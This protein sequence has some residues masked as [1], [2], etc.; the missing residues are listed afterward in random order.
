MSA[1][2]R[3]VLPFARIG[4][5]DLP[6]VGGKT[7][8]LG[9]L[10]RALGPQG[11]AVPDGFAVTAAAY[12]DFLDHNGL[13]PVLHDLLDGLDVDDV[14]RLQE[15][16]AAAREALRG[17]S[18][19]PALA[20]EIRA[21]YARLDPGGRLSVAVRSSATAED[22][23]TASFAGQQETFLH[24]RG[25]DDVLRRVQDCFASLFLARA[26]AYR[27]HRGF[28]QLD[29]ALSVAVQ[30]MVRTDTGAAGV[31]FTLDPDTGHRGFVYLSGAWGLGENVV[32]GRVVPDAWYVH[33]STL[34]AGHDGVV[35][36]VLGTKATALRWDP[37]GG[38]L[39]DTPVP[40]A[41]R[42]RFCLDD[43]E[44]RQLARWALAV[45]AQFTQ[46]R[47]EPTPMDLEW[48]RDGETGELF[49]LQ[50]RPETVH[51]QRRTGLLRTWRLDATGH[52][53]LVEGLAVGGAVG[54]GT[55]RVC[56]SAEDLAAVQPGDVLV[57]RTTDPDWEPVM[58]VA[59]AIVTEEGGRTSHAAI[60]SR[61][62]GIPAVVAATGARSLLH[63]GQQITVSCAEGSIG[64]VYAGALAAEVE[65]VDLTTLPAPRT[66]ILVNVGDPERALQ[67]SLLPVDGVGLA[68]MEFVFAGWVGVHPL[69]LL[70]PERTSPEVQA[71]LARRCAGHATPQAWFVDRL[72][73]GIGMLAAAFH[74]RPV[75][76]RFSDFKSNEYAHLLG[77]EA[78]EPQEENPMIGW[79]GASRYHHPAFREAFAL[80]V[81]AVR[82]VREALGLTNLHLMIPFCRT[83]EEGRQ[84]IAELARGG[85]RR[86]DG[87]LELYV[88][89]EIPS[90]VLLAEEFAKDFDG[91]SI[92]SNDLTQ[93]VYGVDRDSA[94]V[95]DLF[96]DD[97]PALQRACAMLLEAAHGAGRKVG[98]CGQAPSDH[99]AFAAFLVEH[100]ID[101]ISLATDAVLATRQ[102][103][104]EAEQR[105]ERAR[106]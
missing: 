12:R 77:G 32:Q 81:A 104:V 43:E 2:S 90:N 87:G 28:G 70:H 82:Q 19:P 3:W 86:G 14:A 9:E 52:A 53:P 106:T 41:D 66:H 100:G 75:I 99:P 23:P 22:L 63:A 59:A 93:L 64:R 73:Q 69:A 89:A 18:M 44:V 46:V 50:A 54:T 37:Q 96:D 5:E 85:L 67:A 16:S 65:E 15:R 101:S 92:G 58:K 79:R 76:L 36:R 45:E 97:G 84:V 20:A 42:D 74:P 98:I 1:P 4:H 24:V 56:E 30:R 11:V 88:M 61:E 72:A 80:E 49:L 25:A 95:A 6:R 29:V 31:A 83:P 27:A 62:H 78:F 55:A 102:A 103:V 33:R 60:V 21:A 38:A 34:E 10:I 7:A 13:V 39:A 40:Q 68:R 57:A 47:G 35:R 71:E 17:G 91:F 94:M 8:S 26:V 51:G 48:G 105:L